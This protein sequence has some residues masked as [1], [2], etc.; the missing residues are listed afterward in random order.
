MS[1]V[2]YRVVTDSILGGVATVTDADVTAMLVIRENAPSIAVHFEGD[3]RPASRRNVFERMV[4]DWKTWGGSS[5]RFDKITWSGVDEESGAPLNEQIVYPLIVQDNL[6]GALAIFSTGDGTLDGNAGML[7]P[8]IA[9]RVELVI[10]NAFL[11]EHTMILA[12][13]DPLTGLF[14]RRAFNEG[15]A[16]EFERSRRLSMGGRDGNNL[17]VIMADVDY[18]KKFNDTYGHQLGDEVLKMVGT[19]L[20]G[21][22]RRATDIVAR[23]GG[24]EFV[25]VAPD[26]SA[27]NARA[28]AERI[29]AT[30]EKTPVN[31]A[32]GPLHVTASFGVATY[33][34]CGAT[35]VES[36]VEQAD[37]A[38]YAAKKNGRNRVEM[39]PAHLDD[40]ARHGEK[41]ATAV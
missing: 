7:L 4:S 5:L 21:V 30:L 24:E 3:N 26:T 12:T 25:M 33:P 22:A 31:S 16:R 28:I 17:S 13:T 36:L 27:E 10:E 15:Y 35:T 23:Y 29:R 39:A 2:D 37:E 32:S 34:G 18:F 11:H 41:R 40:P 20:L 14:N 6:I 8:I 9:R 1:L 19:V 38:L